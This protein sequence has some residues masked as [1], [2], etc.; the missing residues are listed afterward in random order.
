MAINEV[1]TDK[2]VAQGWIL[3]CVAFPTT[4]DVL[5]EIT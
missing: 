1:L 2:E 5:V 3:T 4:D